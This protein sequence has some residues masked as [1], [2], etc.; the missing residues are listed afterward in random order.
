MQTLLVRYTRADLESVPSFGAR[1][2]KGMLRNWRGSVQW[3]PRWGASRSGW[4]SAISEQ[5]GAAEGAG[6]VHSGKEE[7][8][9]NLLA[10]YRA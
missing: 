10:A 5:P 8:S 2:L 9:N 4:S 6:L 7:L 1:S 3:P